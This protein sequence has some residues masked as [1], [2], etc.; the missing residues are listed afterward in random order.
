M[1]PT[2]AQDLKRLAEAVI[3]AKDYDMV[4]TAMQRFDDHCTPALILSLLAERAMLLDAMHKLARLGNG[5]HFGNSEGNM[6]ARAAIAQI[7]GAQP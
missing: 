1:T 7:E 6:I 2:Q 5:D 4:M 3:E